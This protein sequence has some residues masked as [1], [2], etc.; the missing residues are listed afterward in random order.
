[1]AQ[2]C[3]VIVIA[4]LMD[5]TVVEEWGGLNGGVVE[6]CWND[7]PG[8]DRTNYMPRN[9]RTKLGIVQN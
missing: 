3:R 6:V 7:D 5:A 9:K 4:V 2:M 1:M 8:N